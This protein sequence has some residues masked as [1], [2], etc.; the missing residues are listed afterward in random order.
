MADKVYA[1]GLFANQA[2]DGAP[3]FVVGSLAIIKDKFMAWLDAQEADGKGYV[4]LNVV[5]QKADA[6]K[7]SVS[8]DTWKPKQ[9]DDADQLPGA[10][11]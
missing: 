1:D 5:K 9:Q 3:D 2:R 8:L 11:F 4:R 6:S 7:W 10:P